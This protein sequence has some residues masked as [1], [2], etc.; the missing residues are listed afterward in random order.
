MRRL[1]AQKSVK[2]YTSGDR[3]IQRFSTANTRYGYRVID[4]S[5]QVFSNAV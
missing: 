2:Q 5:H 1:F 4:E 3:R